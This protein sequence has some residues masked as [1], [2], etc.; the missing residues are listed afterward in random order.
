MCLDRLVLS[1][2]TDIFF[3]FYSLSHL[4][5]RYKCIMIQ[6][7]C[8]SNFNQK[9]F[10]FCFWLENKT[11]QNPQRFKILFIL[12]DLFHSLIR[13]SFLLHSVA[14]SPYLLTWCLT[15][16]F[17][18]FFFPFNVQHSMYHHFVYCFLF[19]IC[20]VFSSIWISLCVETEL[21]QIFGFYTVFK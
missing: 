12:F 6:T 8:L 11:L 3:L 7:L 14:H 4:N 5:Y 17:H 2:P 10:D 13:S 9:R 15:L 16:F 1:G 21:Y 20:T 18:S 19:G